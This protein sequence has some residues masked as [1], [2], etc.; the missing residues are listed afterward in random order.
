MSVSDPL[1]HEA[2]RH[3]V[4]PRP[5]RGRER[6]HEE[7]VRERHR[8]L[9]HPG[10]GRVHPAAVEPGDRAEERPEEQGE[11]RRPDAD[12]ERDLR[13]VEQAQEL[14]ARERG[15]G[16]EDE[17]LL[18]DGAVLLELPDPRPGPGGELVL[19][20]TARH[21][22]GLVRPVAEDLRGERS[23]GEGDEEEQDDEDGARERQPVAPQPE[24][25]AG[26]VATRLDALVVELVVEGI[27]GQADAGARQV[28]RDLAV[29]GLGVREV[30]H[31]GVGTEA[32]GTQLST[33]QRAFAPVPS[34]FSSRKKICART[35]EPSRG[36]SA[37]SISALRSYDSSTLYGATSSLSIGNGT[38]GFSPVVQR[39]FVSPPRRFGPTRCQASSRFSRA[40][41]VWM[42]RIATRFAS[43]GERCL[44][45]PLGLLRRLRR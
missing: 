16:P 21:E 3:L 31:L 18:V 32:R 37:I 45:L 23:A 35:P 19:V 42:K 44:G 12:L 30:A 8:E 5:E 24:P 36:R 15:V 2:E 6:D 7:Q 33:T 11:Q 43:G 1:A 39:S 26:P 41:A 22:E 13:A 27:G 38:T 40:T 17:E 29:R 25:D 4:Q 28:R 34:R 14:V 20:E 9:E 10:D